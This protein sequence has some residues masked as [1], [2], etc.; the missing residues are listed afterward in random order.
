[1]ARDTAPKRDEL[2]AY[3]ARSARALVLLHEQHMRRFLA[4]WQEAH[5]AGVRLPETTNPHYASLETLLRHV[6]A[7]GRGYM[8]WIAE[9]LD[10]DDPGIDEPPRADEVA[11]RADAYLEHLLERWR[12]P[13]ADVPEERLEDR[14]YTSRWGEPFTIDSM[15]E[16]AVLHPQ[17][18]AFQ[19]EELM[20]S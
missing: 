11:A 17:R 7:A 15:L 10:L 3:R 6:L 19:L 16:H 1:M 8:T 12:L 2:Q 13:L 5:A 20:G 4:T 14:A 9:Q 18:H